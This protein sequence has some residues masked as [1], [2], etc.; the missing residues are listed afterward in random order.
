VDDVEVL[1]AQNHRFIE[2]CRQG[3]WPMLQP[4]L[5]P[6]FSY[7]D[8][9]T[10]EVWDMDRYI[11]DLQDDPASTLVID[12][13]VIHVAGDTAVVSARSRSHNG[14]CNRYL[15]KYERSGDSWLCVHACVWPLQAA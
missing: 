8:G 1:D 13:V 6:T 14:G 9:T 15:D 4:V 11:A 2:A 7:L 5:A 10:G 3:S 12:Q